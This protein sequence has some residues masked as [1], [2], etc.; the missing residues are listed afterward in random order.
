MFLKRKNYFP[1]LILLIGI[2]SVNQWSSIPIGDT[3]FI[4]TIQLLTLGYI[5]RYIDKCGGFC[6]SRSYRL[7][8]VYLLV[9]LAGS[10]RGLF[11]A[12]NYWEYKQLITGSI[13]LLLPLLIYVFADPKILSQ[14]FRFWYKWGVVLFFIF[15]IWVIS[16]EAYQFYIAPILLIGCFLP[17]VKYEKWRYL[18]LFLLCLMIFADFG[19]RA[20]VL[21]AFICLMMSVVYYLSKYITDKILRIV[22]WMC[23]I[24][25]VI[26]LGLGFIGVFN[27][28]DNTATEYSGQFVEKKIINGD[29][30]EDDVSV[31]TRTFLYTEVIESALR[32]NYVLWGRTPARGNDSVVFGSYLAEELHTGKYERFRNE[33]CHP[34]VFTWIGLIGMIL[35]SLLYLQASW[36]A[37]Y[38]SNNLLIKLMG[39]Y[40]A[41][42][43]GVGWI[44][45]INDF[46]ILSITLWAMIAMCF[47]LQFRNMTNAE[48]QCWINN[49]LNFKKY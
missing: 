16:R 4:W 43:W 40:V 42:R 35:Y 8:C 24:I 36:L 33:F 49:L 28:F 44:E 13:S 1:F 21:K 15:F 14:T 34:N 22:H 12:E 27:V 10:V 45:D 26:L 2:I 32:H 23:Y 48:M 29:V 30:I 6:P 39:C 47:S 38:R 19:A 18:I 20:Q 25:P 11:V 41:F 31:D 17:V 9:V 7:L 37:L 3:F 46:Y 5:V